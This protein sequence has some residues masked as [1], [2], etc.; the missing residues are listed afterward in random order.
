MADFWQAAMG[1]L[2]HTAAAGGAVLLVGWLAVRATRGAAGRQR[3]AAWAVRAAVLVP[4]LCLFPAWLTVRLPAGWAGRD[5]RASQ[6]EASEPAPAPRPVTEAVV[7]EGSAD[8]LP[9]DLFPAGE[10]AADFPAPVAAAPAVVEPDPEPAPAASPPTP[11]DPL[12]EY[13]P[14]VLGGYALVGGLLALRLV[15]G[16]VGLLRLVKA[17]APA[18][19]RARELFHR[20]AAGV[21]PT[22]R[23]LVTDRV[24]TPVCF[25]LVRPTVLLPRAVAAGPE[26]ELKWVFAHELDHVRRGDPATGWWAGLARSLFFF[27]PWLWLLR[28][29]LVLAQEYLADAAAAAAGGSPADYAAFLVDL[30]GGPGRVPVG[31][32]AVRAGRSDLFRRV[33]MLLQSDAGAARRGSRWAFAAALGVLSTAVLLSGIGFAAAEDD[34]APKPKTV[35]KKVTVKPAKKGDDLVVEV[36]VVGEDDDDAPKPKA[37]PKAKA[38]PAKKSEVAE[39]KKK[40]A[41]AAK[42][43]DAEEVAELVEK[44]EKALAA[45]PAAARAVPPPPTVPGVRIVP[46]APAA[47]ATP[48]AVPVPPAPPAPPAVRVVPAFGLDKDRMAEV[49]KALKKAVEELKDNPEAKEQV[50]KA[51]KEARKAMEQLKEAQEKAVGEA[52]RAAEAGRRAGE[53]ARRQLEEVRRAADADRQAEGAARREGEAAR[54]AERAARLK[55]TEALRAYRD[56]LAKRMAEG[57]GEAADVAPRRPRL[58]VSASDLSEEKAE[59]LKLPADTKGVLV[60]EV[61]KGTPAEKAGVKVDDVILTVAGK[62]TEEPA[63]L[64][65]VLKEVKPGAKVDLVLVRGGKKTTLKGIELAAPEADSPKK[66]DPKPKATPKAEGGADAK[67]KTFKLTEVKPVDGDGQPNVF[68]YEVKPGEGVKPLVREGKPLSLEVKPV[69][70]LRL[71]VPITLE[72][73]PVEGLKLVKPA[74]GAKPVR[75]SPAAGK[76]KFDTTSININDGEFQIDAK[77]GDTAYRVKGAVEGGKAVP[78]EVRITAGE[79]KPAKY[80]TLEAVPEEHRAAVKQLLAGIGGGAK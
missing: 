20:L 36:V 62:P 59:E 79:E 57:A 69:E 70:G 21:R 28:R 17:A 65:T 47:P 34:D 1:W 29:D 2:G 13:A 58:G 35:E 44:L 15:L 9:A 68:R 46:P 24:S 45:P 32:H 39:L 5:T 6:V 41:A 51:L 55:A 78:S 71:D 52:R 48:R 43:G 10:W 60:V 66:A 3:L 49:E 53:D 19:A 37:A 76:V 14:A 25:G 42:A 54:D 33:N 72:A 64:V 26:A 7:Y 27:V 16:Q 63:G 23:V 4:V 12:R 31:A 11:A 56:D 38:A 30:S 50:E 8:P 75:I 77:A 22:P 67:P 74:E 73:K 40:I 61:I 80:K 18:P